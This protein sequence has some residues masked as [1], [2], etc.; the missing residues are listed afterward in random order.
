MKSNGGLLMSQIRHLGDRIFEKIL[1]ESGVEAFSG[2]QG[3]ILY[4]LWEY[5][6]LTI[7]EIGKMTSLAKSTLTGMLDLMERNGLVVRVPD[8]VNRKQ[9]FI[10][11]TET[12]KNAQAKYDEVSNKMTDLTYSGFSGAEIIAFE[13][14][15][16]RIKAN[17]ERFEN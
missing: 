15:L 13:D 17:L 16:A 10:R 6:S 2:A 4:V 3:R 14:M 7:T 12:A 5:G 1:R 9:I 11:L 8:R